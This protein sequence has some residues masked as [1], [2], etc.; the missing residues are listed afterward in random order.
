M[1]ACLNV[2][3]LPFGFRDARLLRMDIGS[4][5]VIFLFYV[6][7]VHASAFHQVENGLALRSLITRAPPTPPKLDDEDVSSTCGFYYDSVKTDLSAF[8]LTFS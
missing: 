6:Y 5:L 8:R 2:P 4:L 7:V 1:P 3:S